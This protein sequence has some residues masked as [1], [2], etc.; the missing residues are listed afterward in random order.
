MERPPFEMA[1]STQEQP[2]GREMVS[3]ELLSNLFKSHNFNDRIKKVLELMP[4]VRGR[5]LGF[6]VLKHPN[7]EKLYFTEICGGPSVNST[8]LTEEIDIV[9]KHLVEKG[10]IK[11]ADIPIVATIHFHPDLGEGPEILPSTADLEALSGQRLDYWFDEGGESLP[12]EIVATRTTDREIRMLMMQEPPHY[13]PKDRQNIFDELLASLEQCGSEKEAVDLL[14]HYG[15]KTK[16]LRTHR[17]RITAGDLKELT[18]LF[19]Y[20]PKK[21]AEISKGANL[22]L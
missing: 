14:K 3:K 22:D 15:Y 8:D 18:Q 16:V 13:R 12:I 17:R 2:P 21:V 6:A 20:D 11:F 4:K 5:E 9:A 19:A 1:Q 7:T 10:E